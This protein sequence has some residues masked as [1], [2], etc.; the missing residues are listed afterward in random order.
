[1]CGQPPD[2]PLCD[3]CYGKS[4]ENHNIEEHELCAD[5]QE[6]IKRFCF[7]CGTCSDEPI[8]EDGVCK[9]CLDHQTWYKENND[10]E[11]AFEEIDA[12]KG[13]EG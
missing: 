11:E 7:S 9:D 6:L 3:E 13:D 12:P 8:E 2:S 5:C 10:D 1:M 4:Q